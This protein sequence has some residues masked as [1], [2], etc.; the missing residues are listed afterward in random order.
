[1]F[2]DV[3]GSQ[4]QSVAPQWQGGGTSQSYNYALKTHMD[5]KHPY[6]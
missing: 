6:S 1:M 4:I 5:A 3:W 2:F